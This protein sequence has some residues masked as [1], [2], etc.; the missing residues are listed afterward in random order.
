M[1]LTGCLRM[2]SGNQL[3]T[4]SRSCCTYLQVLFNNTENLNSVPTPC[5]DWTTI[6]PP[7]SLTIFEE[8]F[9]PRPIPFV[10]SCYPSSIYPNALNRFPICSFLM[11]TPVSVHFISRYNLSFSSSFSSYYSWLNNLFVISTSNLTLPVD[12]NFSAFDCKFNNTC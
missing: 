7:R 1:Y 10:L 8:M 12:V 4:S 9:S 2:R 5:L 3:N 11:P 6:S